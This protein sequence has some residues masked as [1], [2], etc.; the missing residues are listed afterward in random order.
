VV[1]RCCHHARQVLALV[2]PPGAIWHFTDEGAFQE[3]CTRHAA[4]ALG[5]YAMESGNLDEALEALEPGLAVANMSEHGFIYDTRVRILLRRGER[6]AAYLI[7]AQILAGDPDFGD[8]QDLRYDED[9]VAWRAA[10]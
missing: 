10:N 6:D 8:F 5:W 1:A 3:E 7:V 2:P 9:Y 4:N